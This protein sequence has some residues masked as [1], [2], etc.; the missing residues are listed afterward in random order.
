MEG[1]ESGRQDDDGFATVIWQTRK[2]IP[3]REKSL[4][5]SVR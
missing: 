1:A 4:I 2:S 3:L 5:L